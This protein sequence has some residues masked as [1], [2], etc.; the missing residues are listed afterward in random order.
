MD[1]IGPIKVSGL[2]SVHHITL[3]TKVELYDFSKVSASLQPNNVQL[4]LAALNGLHYLLN[5]CSYI[6]TD[7]QPISVSEPTTVSNC[8]KSVP[9]CLNTPN[10]PLHHM[11][12]DH[13]RIPFESIDT[14]FIR[15]Q[16]E[17]II[18]SS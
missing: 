13:K 12:Y 4:L 14:V 15:A 2:T 9:S 1:F 11:Y 10:K 5:I 8:Q 6:R 18:F 17:R 7:R 3:L 16:Q